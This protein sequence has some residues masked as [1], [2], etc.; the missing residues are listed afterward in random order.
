[1]IGKGETLVWSEKP[2]GLWIEN[3]EVD[4]SGE[5]LLVKDL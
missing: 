3:R 5:Q 4:H 1:M 2:E